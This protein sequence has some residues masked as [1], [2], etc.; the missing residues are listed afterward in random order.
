MYN[1]TSPYSGNTSSFYSYI[2]YIWEDDEYGSA[3]PS[4]GA[5]NIVNVYQPYKV[6]KQWND[7]EHEN[8]RPD[9]IT[10]RFYDPEN[11]SEA[12]LVKEVPVSD[13]DEQ[14]YVIDEL[15]VQRADGTYI[16]YLVGEDDVDGYVTRYSMK[17]ITGFWLDF[18]YSKT[19]PYIGNSSNYLTFAGNIERTPTN[20]YNKDY[21]EYTSAK[22]SY[23]WKYSSENSGNTSVYARDL[24]HPIFVQKSE[25]T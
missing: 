3:T 16:K 13:A 7:E 6:T 2:K 21:M 4:F 24:A 10:L 5:T 17:D 15:P 8:E 14:E 1:A 12:V 22:Y 25:E 9:T 19:E 11:P 18:D 20:S 23:A